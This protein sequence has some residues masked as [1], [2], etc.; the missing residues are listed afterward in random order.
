MIEL[1]LVGGAAAVGL[2]ARG[3]YSP[4]SGLFGAAIGR[5]PRDRRRIYLTFD[6]GPNPGATETILDTLAASGVPASFFM[7]GEHVDRFPRIAR[8]VADAGHA[9]GN[10]SYHHIKLHRHGPARVRAEMQRAHFAIAEGTGQAPRMFRAP[11]GYRTPF[12]ARAARDLGYTVFGW[13]Y[14]VWDSARP[15]A[16]VIR[17]RV[18]ERLVPGAI[19]LLHDGDGDDPDGDRRQTAAAVAGIIRDTRDSG[20]ELRLLSELS[21]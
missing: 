8:A 3:V 12:V 4:N 20:F 5:G 19:V 1:G 21:T 9:I 10:H 18:R 2:L 16:D 13:T 15:T 6:D 14:G 17:R 11:H 7:V